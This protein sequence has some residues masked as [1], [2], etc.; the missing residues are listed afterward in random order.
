RRARRGPAARGD[1]RGESRRDVRAR[2]LRDAP[3]GAAAAVGVPAPVPRDRVLRRA[4]DVLD[5]AGRAAGH[6]ARPRRGVRAGERARRLRPGRAGDEPGAGRVNIAV[7]L[8]VGALGGVGA[9][10]RLLLDGFV[11][12]RAPSGF[13]WGTL[14][15]NATGS[16]AL[17]LLG[18]SLLVGTGL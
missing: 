1:L 11:S 7:I 5:R 6:A 2:L 9:I 14:A 13:P 8:G 16:F 15:V 4:D 3:A 12:S 17:G 10:A 18:T